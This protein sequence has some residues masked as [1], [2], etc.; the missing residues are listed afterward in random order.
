MPAI[1]FVFAKYADPDNE[2]HADMLTCLGYTRE[3]DTILDSNISEYVLPPL[4][5]ARLQECCW[6]FCQYITK[7][8]KYFHPRDMNVFHYT[9]K[10]HYLVHFGMVASYMNPALGSCHSGEDSME[11]VKRLISQSAI[12]TRPATAL[13]KAMGRYADGLAGSGLAFTNRLS[14]AL[15]QL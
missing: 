13:K 15:V 2:Q 14:M 8:V 4:D 10:M 12:G 1:R 5:A 11:I 6:R 3:T 7:L 9:L